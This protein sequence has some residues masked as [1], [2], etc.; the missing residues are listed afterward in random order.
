MKTT[1]A[2]HRHPP[3]HRQLP[4][5]L[6]VDVEVGRGVQ[7]VVRLP[8]PLVVEQRVAQLA[9]DQLLGRSIPLL[10]KTRSLHYC[11]CEHLISDPPAPCGSPRGV[12]G[13]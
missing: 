7:H 1:L 5:G 13:G 12:S 3:G 10:I 4:V 11:C 2:G 8:R 9:L 6:A